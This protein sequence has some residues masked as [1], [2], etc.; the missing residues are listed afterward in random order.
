[1]RASFQKEI[2]MPGTFEVVLFLIL[3][4]QDKVQVCWRAKGKLNNGPFKMTHMQLLS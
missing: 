3:V 2:L 4:K 1:M